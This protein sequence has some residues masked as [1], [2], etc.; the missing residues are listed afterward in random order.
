MDILLLMAGFILILGG[1]VFMALPIVPGAAIIYLGILLV[2]WADDFSRIGG[3]MLVVLAFLA[4]AGSL[5]D[6]LAGVM[7]A[8][9]GGAS[10]WGVLGAVL[11]ALAGLP[12]G[13]PGVILGPAIGAVT[14]EYLKNPEFKR[15]SRAGA[16]SLAGFLLGIVAKYVV[17]G[18][19]VGIALVAY[20]F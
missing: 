6:N 9:Y 1:L 7:G 3:V 4:I 12:F 2:A 19:M 13:L 5:V 11:G 14:F 17:G 8:R 18:L 16:G 20:F 15:A 10:T